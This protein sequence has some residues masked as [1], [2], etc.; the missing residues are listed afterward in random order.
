MQ[1][2][3]LHTLESQLRW[4][5]HGLR[6]MAQSLPLQQEGQVKGKMAAMTYV[7]LK[8]P[9]IAFRPSWEQWGWEKHAEVL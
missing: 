4:R 9:I 6:F 3:R 8:N 1:A 5:L 2:E 7:S